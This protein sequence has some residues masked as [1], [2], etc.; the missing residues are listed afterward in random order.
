MQSL[1]LATDLSTGSESAMRRAADLARR[2]DCPWF[3]LHVV[4]HDD[5]AAEKRS[6]ERLERRLELL[7]RLAGRAPEVWIE[8][9]DVIDQITACTRWA[10]VDLLVL[11]GGRISRYLRDLPC[12]VLI[13]PAARE[14]EPA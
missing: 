6:A 3:I 7:T 12:E 8:R 11:G 9:G 5:A 14:L 2:Y 4:E 13:V 10:E 1:M